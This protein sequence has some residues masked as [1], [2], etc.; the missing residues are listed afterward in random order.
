MA[1]AQVLG[2]DADEVFDAFVKQHCASRTMTA[3]TS[4]NRVKDPIQ[5]SE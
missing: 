2:M 1:L 3:T 4:A 5:H